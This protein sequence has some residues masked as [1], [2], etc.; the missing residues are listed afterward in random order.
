VIPSTSTVLE[1]G[2][3]LA[4]VVLAGA[5]VAAACAAWVGLN[6]WKKEKAWQEDFEL[7]RKLLVALYV[8]HDAVRIVRNP[9]GWSHEEEVDEDTPE[10]ERKLRGLENKYEKR[11]TVLWEAEKDMRALMLEAEAIWGKEL[12]RCEDK[13]RAIEVELRVTIE[14]FLDFY[15]PIFETQNSQ[16]ERERRVAVRR[17]IYGVGSSDEFGA[18][19]QTAVEGVESY[20]REKLGSKRP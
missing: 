17:I 7:A 14:E 2:A 1:I 19:Y 16:E 11:L 13:L 3:L 9:F 15:R 4:N 18:R 8:R 5:A 6:S 10:S 20:L 12:N